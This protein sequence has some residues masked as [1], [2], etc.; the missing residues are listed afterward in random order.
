M[1]GRKKTVHL[2]LSSS[3]HSHDGHE[4]TQLLRLCEV[5]DT[6]AKL[7]AA[8]LHVPIGVFA[9]CMLVAPVTPAAGE[10]VLHC[11]LPRPWIFSRAFVVVWQVSGWC[12][13]A[14][15]YCAVNPLYTEILLSRKF[16]AVEAVAASM[17]TRH[18]VYHRAAG[19]RYACCSGVV[20]QLALFF[21]CRYSP[22]SAIK[23]G[24]SRDDDGSSHEQ[25]GSKYRL[26]KQPSSVEP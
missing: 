15:Q 5:F 16:N 23:R 17:T 25:E 14:P 26:S 2:S 20:S 12:Q 7:E 3:Q 4:S 19:E 6:D 18:L 9:V 22:V 13:H 8:F 24:G 1:P 11:T 10:L 21:C